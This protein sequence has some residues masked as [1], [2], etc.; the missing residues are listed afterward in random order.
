M[1]KI[2]HFPGKGQRKKYIDIPY[3]DQP[4]TPEEAVN[5][6]T[7][8]MLTEVIKLYIENNWSYRDLDMIVGEFKD[9]MIRTAPEYITR[10]HIA[11]MK[12]AMRPVW[13]DIVESIRSQYD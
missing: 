3:M 13:L 5:E 4:L 9:V 10:N 1:A 11:Q 12:D 2:L 6:L 7:H 8:Q